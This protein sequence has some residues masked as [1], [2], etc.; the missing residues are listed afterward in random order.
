MEKKKKE[1]ADAVEQAALTSVGAGVGGAGGAT[2]GV[3]ELAAQQGSVTPLSAGMVIGAGAVV[4][5]LAFFYGYRAWRR[6]KQPKG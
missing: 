2:F 5:G 1:K 3:L 4:G 6:L